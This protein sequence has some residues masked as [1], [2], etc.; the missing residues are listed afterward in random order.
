MTKRN[1]R[2]KKKRWRKLNDMIRNSENF[3]R[4]KEKTQRNDFSTII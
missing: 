3:T 4:R 1:H 2:T